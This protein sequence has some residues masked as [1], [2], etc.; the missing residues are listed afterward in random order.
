MSRLKPNNPSCEKCPLCRRTI[1]AV[2]VACVASLGR[3]GPKTTLLTVDNNHYY[4]HC[5]WPSF[6][7]YIAAGFM[8]FSLH[9]RCWR[10][11]IKPRQTQ[12]NN[13]NMR[14]TSVAD[15][16][17][18]SFGTIENECNNKY[19]NCASYDCSCAARDMDSGKF[20][21]ICVLCLARPFAS[22]IYMLSPN[23]DDYL[24]WL[25]AI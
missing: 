9:R 11:R 1:T 22:R 8:F 6:G 23:D 25:S 14:W 3:W 10:A 7:W 5:N 19:F 15:N 21:L 4:G 24:F 20:V 2:P 13:Q 16:I 12:S 17:Y 18:R